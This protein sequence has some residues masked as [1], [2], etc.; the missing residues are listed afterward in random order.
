MRHPYLFSEKELRHCIDGYEGAI[1]DEVEKLDKNTVLSASEHDLIAHFV[2]KYTLVPPT[3]RR[4]E[5]YVESEGDAKIDVSRRFD[6]GFF[7][8]EGP[9]FIEGSYVKIAVPFG[10]DADLFQFRASTFSTAPPIG[11]VHRDTLQFTFQ[12]V[13]LS[14]EQIKAQLNQTLNTI[15]QYLGWIRRDCEGWNGRVENVAR[16]RIQ[17]RKS[18]LLRQS[19]M[20]SA[21]GLPIK[22]RPDAVSTIAVSVA[23]RRPT[24]TAPS[25]P[26]AVFRPEPTLAEAEYDYILSVIDNLAK[27]IERSPTTFVGM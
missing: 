4:D 20:V 21:L 13:N 8:R 3:L 17:D 9:H 6:Y 27:A 1:R 24:V 25:A 12:D 2:E 18:Q 5:M 23:R 14:S 22:R 26:H 7:D 11:E 19:N 10:G 15:E 16:Q